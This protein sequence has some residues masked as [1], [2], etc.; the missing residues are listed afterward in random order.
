MRFDRIE[1]EKSYGTASQ[2]PASEKSEIVFAGKSNVG[3]SSLLNK[4][5]NRKNLAR[6]S[7]SPG[8]TITVNFFKGDGVYFVDL[9]GYGYAKRN[10]AELERWSELMEGYF[11]SGRNI[12]LAVQLLDMRHAPTE[13]DY[14]MLDFLKNSHIPFVIVLT[15]ADKLNKSETESRRKQFEEELKDYGAER[16]E[17]SCVTGKGVTELQKYIEKTIEVN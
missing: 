17:F 8:K 4:L 11:G 12:S 1:F 3:K 6:V 2:L 14:T 10:K 16:I 13:N 7:S 5:F 9:P 15:K